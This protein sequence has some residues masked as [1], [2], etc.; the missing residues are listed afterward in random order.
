M[1]KAESRK[2]KSENGDHGRPDEAAAGQDLR[3]PVPGRGRGEV[4]GGPSKLA[5]RAAAL[6]P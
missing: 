4:Q 5:F 1:G 3:R 6:N 2:Q